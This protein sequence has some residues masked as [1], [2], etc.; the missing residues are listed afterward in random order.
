M[1]GGE[2]KIVIII[3]IMEKERIKNNDEGEE[4]INM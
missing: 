4:N 2:V 1:E 3:I